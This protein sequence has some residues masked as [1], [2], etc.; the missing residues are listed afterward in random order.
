MSFYD[1]VFL[2]KDNSVS[3][4]HRNFRILAVEIDEAY[5]VAWKG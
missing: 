5:T 3:T 2:E 4:H 1:N